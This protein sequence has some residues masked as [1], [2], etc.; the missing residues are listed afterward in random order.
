MNTKS[1]YDTVVLRSP[2]SHNQFLTYLD[3]TVRSLCALYK[4]NYV[5]TK[6]NVWG[7]PVSINSD[8]PVYDEYFTAVCSNILYLLTGDTDR[9]TEFVAESDSA[10]LAVWSEKSRS[11]RFVDRGYS[12]V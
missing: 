2:C 10:Y 12:D 9:K 6:D 5:I 3:S 1:I 11:K 8:I 7:V 4:K